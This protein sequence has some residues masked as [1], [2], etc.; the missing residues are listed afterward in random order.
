M[1]AIRNVSIA[2]IAAVV[3]LI[4]ARTLVIKI[5]P[6]EIGVLTRFDGLDEHD[7]GPGYHM[8]LPWVHRWSR[9]DATVQ[10]LHMMSNL[11]ANEEGRGPL[12]VKSREGASVTMDVSIK[13]QIS[14]DKVW[15]IVR[16]H[17]TGST[18]RSGYKAKV[19]DRAD[20]VLQEA[21][22]SIN[23]EDFYDPE[24]RA[25]VARTMEESLTADLKSLDVDLIAILIRDVQF[26]E[27]FEKRIKEKALAEE[28]I[29]LNQ[30]QA[31]A[32]EY[33]GRTNK[34][35]AETEAIVQVI[36]QERE[37]ELTTLTAENNR[38]IEALRADY[39]KKVVEIKSDADLHAAQQKAAATKL[40]KESEAAGQTLR[41]KAL[42]VEGGDNY[43]ALELARNLN[44][45]TMQISTQATNPL[46]VDAI[47]HALGTK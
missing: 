32:A 16:Q 43:V 5:E 40:L 2:V 35:E 30:A 41:R 9:M 47:L 45:G 17:G 29:E 11:K 18:R 33:R 22:G 23:T 10:T 15:E 37:K 27:D 44:L 24:K 20:R 19:E 31:Q 28:A 12:I 25:D 13:Y 34:I 6:G 4:L 1:K 39:Q 14:D 21:L 8:S 7:Y 3:L 36:D 46:D 42:A 38:K 26:Q